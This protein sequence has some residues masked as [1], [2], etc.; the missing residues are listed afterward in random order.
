[1][2]GNSPEDESVVWGPEYHR[3]RILNPSPRPLDLQIPSTTIP[4]I[5]TPSVVRQGHHLIHAMRLCMAEPVL[6]KRV[7]S[8]FIDMGVEVI[9]RKQNVRLLA[10]CGLARDHCVST[11]VIMVAEFGNR[12]ERGRQEGS[13]AITEDAC[14]CFD[15]GGSYDAETVHKVNVQSLKREF[16]DAVRMH[17]V[18]GMLT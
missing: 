12:Q 6:R 15:I 10:A 13:V 16:V 17:D 3:S 5:S 8:G 2:F 1:M 9:L 7:S 18:L 11:T 4:P 14:A